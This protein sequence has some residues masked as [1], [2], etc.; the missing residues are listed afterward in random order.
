M[1]A[2]STQVG[3][4]HY[5]SKSIQ[6]WDAMRAWMSKEEFAG[7]LRG[8][9]IKYLARCNDKGGVEDLRKARH[10]IDKLIELETKDA[11]HPAGRINAGHNP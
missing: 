9:A 8:N 11:H 2:D 5:T 10:Y 4:S 3:G 6:P 1:I 7:F